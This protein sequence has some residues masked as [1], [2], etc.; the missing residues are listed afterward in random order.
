M[1]AAAGVSKV[2]VGQNGILSTPAVSAIIR[3]RKI[4]GGLEFSS[5]PPKKEGF[6]SFIEYLANNVFIILLL[7]GLS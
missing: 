7:Q 2:L 5:F 6:F 4:F 1:S 3:E